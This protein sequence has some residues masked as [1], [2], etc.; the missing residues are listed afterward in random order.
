V[1]ICYRWLYDGDMSLSGSCN[2]NLFDPNR[3]GL[4][5]E[6]VAD[7]ADALYS[8]W[9]R[10][11]HCFRTRRHD[12]STNAYTY[13]RGLLTMEDQR[14]FTNIERRLLGGDGQALQ[15]FMSDS[16]W[17]GQS[18]L[19]QIQAEISGHPSLQSGGLLILDESADEKAGLHSAGAGRQHNGRLGKVDICQVTTAL[20]YAHPQTGTWAIVD[21]ELFL[22]QAWFSPEFAELRE[23]LGVPKDR[24]FSTKVELGLQMIKRVHAQGL[25]FE[26]VACDDL[27]GRNQWFRAQLDG[28]KI[29]YAA[30]VPADTRV[31][32][33]PPQVGVERSS[34]KGSR[35]GRKQGRRQ[36]RLK[37]LSGHKPQE[38]RALASSGQTLWCHV[39]V[40]HSERGVLEAEFKVFRVWTLTEKMQVRAE[41]L[42]IRRDRDGK[43]RYVLLNAP[44]DSSLEHLIKRSCQRYFAERV[45]EDA[46]SELGWDDFQAQKYL[47]W[48]HHLAL[49]AAALWFVSEVKLNWSQMYAR[50]PEM[51][52][53]LEVN[54][55][56]ALSTANVRELLQALLPVPR[57]SPQQA[58]QLVVRHLVNRAR[59]TSSRLKA[60]REHN[61]SS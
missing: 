14:N 9:Q 45:Y 29:E 50:D 33:K 21:G 19:R 27:Y 60:Q 31:Y 42:V 49:T 10:F 13:M 6:A 5:D 3:W 39:E 25:G 30:E 38:A 54:V 51:R 57:L 23:H 35:R 4:P 52:Q 59:S 37:V 34:N 15:Q 24:Q 47:A 28:Q 18:V 17:S 53:Q 11:C 61:D 44:S 8:F 56:P 48:E 32:L 26:F 36:T 1:E 58:R 20:I 55:L 43:L 12:T 16:P 7:L 41:W 22:P 40:R 2:K 46:K